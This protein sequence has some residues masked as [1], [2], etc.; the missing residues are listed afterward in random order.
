MIVFDRNVTAF[1][2]SGTT[3]AVALDI[4]KATDSIWDAG[5]LNKLESYEIS[6]RV[7]NLTSPYLSTRQLNVLLNGKSS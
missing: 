3:Q 5:L 6:G 4:S 2:R 1:N 7:F